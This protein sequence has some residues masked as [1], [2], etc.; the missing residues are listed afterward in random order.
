MFAGDFR[1]KTAGKRARVG[2]VR[3]R[4]EAWG[5]ILCVT[6]GCVFGHIAMA[7]V[8]VVPKDLILS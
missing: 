6:E 3:V 4:L 2:A 7:G 8:P 1:S 5:V